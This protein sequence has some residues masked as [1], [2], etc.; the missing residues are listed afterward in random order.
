MKRNLVL[1]SL[2]AL[3]PGLCPAQAPGGLQSSNALNPNVSVI[4]WFQGEAGN[5]FAD[6]GTALPAPL[7]L[8][9]AEL[10]IQSVVDPYAKADFFISVDGEGAVELEEGYINWFSLPGG[11]AVK[12]G[13]F[14]AD[15]G[16]FNRTHAPETAFADRPLV[17]ERFFG[18]GLAGTGAALS[19]HVP[20]PWLLAS[21]DVNAANTP[22][23]AEAPA[24]DAA[25]RR[26]LLYT[27][28]L[29]AYLD[30]SDAAGLSMGVSGARGAAGYDVDI[31]PAAGTSSSSTSRA[32]SSTLAGLDM[33]FR[34]KDPSRAIYRS[35]LWQTEVLWSKRGAAGDSSVGTFGLF[36]HMECQFARRWRA[37]ARYD[38]TQLPA[39]RSA[40]EAG[41]LAYLTF[42]PTEFSLVSLQGRRALRFDRTHE[43]LGMLKVTFNIGPHGAHPY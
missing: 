9:E 8:N 11:M 6:P 17:H 4:G 36:S 31:D 40:H 18:E 14:R 24:F 12:A 33:T 3:S 2:F 41:G 28:R 21:L 35:A 30:L 26:D 43:N 29:G 5:R 15:F 27:A 7:R 37:G 10:G 19:W 23:A 20:N 13:K 34:W 39:D 25:R 38:Y 32:L 1:F 22:A 42:M 16:R